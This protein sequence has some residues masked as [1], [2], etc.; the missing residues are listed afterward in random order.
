MT[1]DEDS[2]QDKVRLRRV[3]AD[4]A[5]GTGCHM[6]CLFQQEEAKKAQ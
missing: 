5:Y 2:A 6:H 1:D 3:P 4:Q